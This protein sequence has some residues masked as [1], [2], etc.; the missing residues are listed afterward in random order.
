M[1]QPGAAKCGLGSSST[2]MVAHLTRRNQPAAPNAICASRC[3]SSRTSTSQTTS[4]SAPSMRSKRLSTEVKATVSFP[5]SVSRRGFNPT[6]RWWDGPRFNAKPQKLAETGSTL[7]DVK[8]FEWKPGM[9]LVGE[10]MKMGADGKLYRPPPGKNIFNAEE[11]VFAGTRR[12]HLQTRPDAPRADTL[13]LG[14][15]RRITQQQIEQTFSLHPPLGRQMTPPLLPQPV[16]PPRSW[17]CGITK[18]LGRAPSLWSLTRTTHWFSAEDGP[19]YRRHH[20]L[21]SVARRLRLDRHKNPLLAVLSEHVSS[22]RV[23]DRWSCEPSA[24]RQ[25]RTR[26]TPRRARKPSKKGRLEYSRSHP[27]NFRR[28]GEDRFKHSAEAILPSG[29]PGLDSH[30]CVLGERADNHCGRPAES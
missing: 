28:I 9:H 29:G 18:K 30:R 23:L 25:L 17:L 16:P 26:D 4:I 3:N 15:L 12:R 5:G 22:W 27:N 7:A 14:F 10:I 13:R 11:L 6:S 2:P 20:E 1:A 24:K 21:V 8:K 19:R